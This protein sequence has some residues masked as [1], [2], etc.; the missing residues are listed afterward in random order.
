EAAGAGAAGGGRGHGAREQAHPCPPAHRPQPGGR[1]RGKVRLLRQREGRTRARLHLPP[2]ARDR[3]PH[4]RLA[5]RAR[6]RQRAAPA[7]AA[8]GPVAAQPG[9]RLTD[10]NGGPYCAARTS[11]GAGT[12]VHAAGTAKRSP[13][14]SVRVGA[15]ASAAGVSTATSRS[16]RSMAV[17]RR[18]ATPPSTLLWVRVAAPRIDAVAF[19]R[20]P[21][22]EPADL[23][24]HRAPLLDEKLPHR[25]GEAR[26]AEPVQARGRGRVEA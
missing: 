9:R 20:G 17:P 1:V 19:Q 4:H 2:G 23:A 14:A 25:R 18:F 16:P 12:R 24:R 6:L 22:A 3:A 13:T 5:G 15:P 11:E 7:V 21:L 26:V 10:L 8:A